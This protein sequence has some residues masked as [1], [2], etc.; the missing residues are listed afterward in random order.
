MR[1]LYMYKRYKCKKAVYAKIY[2]YNL[3]IFYTS[4]TVKISKF[5]N[6]NFQDGGVFLKKN[7]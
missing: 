5:R 2:N 7:V 6:S 4:Y 3:K 1:V